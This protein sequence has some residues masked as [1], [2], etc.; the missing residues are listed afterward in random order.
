MMERYQVPPYL[1]LLL[2]DQALALR[3]VSAP[4]SFRG[5][6]GFIIALIHYI[7]YL[8]STGHV[9]GV[10]LFST[11]IIRSKVFYI[12]RYSYN[13]DVHGG[14]SVLEAAQMPRIPDH[15]LD[16]YGQL[17]LSTSKQGMA[18]GLSGTKCLLSVD[19]VFMRLP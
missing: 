9:A 11:V 13:D 14:C 4:S 1:F 7:S 3:R 18:P 17:Y 16:N 12:I 10:L 6:L 8:T 2:W 5:L 15:T 19:Q